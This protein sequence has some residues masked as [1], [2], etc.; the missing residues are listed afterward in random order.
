[1]IYVIF[2]EP[3]RSYLCFIKKSTNMKATVAAIMTK[4]VIVAK[5]E[6]NLFQ[7]IEFFK[8]FKI[9][10][11]PVCNNGNELVG[12]ISV[13]DVVNFFYKALSEGKALNESVLKLN[14]TA[15]N[16]MTANPTCVSSDASIEEAHDILAQGKFQSL[17][18]C[19]E[20][21]IVGIVTN[22]DLVKVLS[23]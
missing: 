11:L 16:I 22:K 9:Q 6:N 3:E 8:E 12:I 4:N 21:K 7:V 2:L 1:M 19:D 14:Y 18:I 20:G 13:N 5:P 17:P 23:F 10:H 15:A